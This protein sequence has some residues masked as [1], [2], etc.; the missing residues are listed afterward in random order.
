MHPGTEELPPFAVHIPS[1]KESPIIVEVPHAG[2]MI[3]PQA[4]ALC[5]APARSLGLDADLYVAD[6]F[7]DAPTVGAHLIFSRMSRYVCDLNREENDWDRHTS[8]MG[9]SVSSPHGV[10]WRKSTEGRPAIAAPLSSEEVE[11]R[12][13]TIYRPYHQALYELVQSKRDKFGF[14]IVLCGHSMPS[15]GRLGER[16]ADVVPGSRG[17]TTT[18]ARVLDLIERTADKAKYGVQHDT[19]YR[20]GFTTGHYG[21]PTNGVH[22]VQIE[23][24][25]RLYMDET[26]LTRTRAKFEECK[27]FC[28]DLVAELGKLDLRI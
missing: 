4:L 7:Y 1:A 8:P 18:D 12:L 27:A 20:G 21:S 11:R 23:F 9:T 24:A 26:S 14:A 2:T 15:F 3:D 10:V 5:T 6:L 28:T 25:R 16:R 13:A 19:P 22:A 17:G